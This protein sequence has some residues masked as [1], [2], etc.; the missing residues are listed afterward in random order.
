MQW[1]EEF[2]LKMRLKP[3]FQITL[4]NLQFS[5]WKAKYGGADYIHSVSVESKADIINCIFQNDQE[6]SSS[7]SSQVSFVG[8]SAMPLTSKSSCITDCMFLKEIG[9]SQLKI[10]NDFGQSDE[11]ALLL[12]SQMKTLNIVRFYTI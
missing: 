2:P 11:E 3:P 6:I 1:F 9:E 5:N 8:G 12:Q 10:E 4:T 7:S